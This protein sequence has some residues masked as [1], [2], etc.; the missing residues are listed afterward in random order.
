MIKVPIPAPPPLDPRLSPRP[1]PRY[2]PDLGS[3]PGPLRASPSLTRNDQWLLQT[4]GVLFSRKTESANLI[5]SQ[6]FSPGGCKPLVASLPAQDLAELEFGTGGIGIGTDGT[7]GS[8]GIRI[9][10]T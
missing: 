10:Y 6:I 5:F 2:C 7:F 9:R 8:C 3:G 1:R 4:V